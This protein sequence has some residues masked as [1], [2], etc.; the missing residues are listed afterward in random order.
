[1]TATDPPIPGHSSQT[2][3]ASRLGADPPHWE[4]RTGRSGDL[5]ATLTGTYPPLTVTA[6]DEE[7]LNKKIK[8]VIMRGML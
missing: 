5:V 1:M 4:V 2:L 7:S 8:I 3:N 6:P